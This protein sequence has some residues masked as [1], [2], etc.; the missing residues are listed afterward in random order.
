MRDR[1]EFGVLCKKHIKD[2]VPWYFRPKYN[3]YT[4]LTFSV[5]HTVKHNLIYL[6]FIVHIHNWFINQF[7]EKKWKTRFYGLICFLFNII[8]STFSQKLNA[9]ISTFLQFMT[10]IF[11]V[12][13]RE[14]CIILAYGCHNYIISRKMASNQKMTNLVNT[15]Y[16][17][18]S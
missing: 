5:I 15:K 11:I 2:L 13:F 6:Y 1:H 3:G 14:L 12:V 7:L 8:F 17:N 16:A 4:T 10:S 18:N 9:S